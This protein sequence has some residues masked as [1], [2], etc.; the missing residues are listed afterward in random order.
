MPQ[1]HEIDYKIYGEDMQFVEVELDPDEA[2][3][4]EAGGMMYMEDGITMETIFGDGSGQQKSG[5]MGTL[6]G[7]GKRLLT[8]E[9]LFMTVFVN[10]GQGKKRLAFGAPYPGRILPIRL[11][12]VGGELIAQKDSFLCAAK[13]VAI[14]I[15]FQKRI[16]VG[17]FGGEG[18][19]MQRLTGDGLCFI[20]A[21]GML[22]ERVL[23]AG[24]TLR[25]DTGCIVAFQPSIDYDIQ[26]VSGIKTALFGGEGLFFATLKGPG[27]IWLQSLPLSRLAGR[28]VQAAPGS[29]RRREEGSIL[30]GL[31]N[32]LDG[33]G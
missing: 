27:K 26:M 16:G 30:G 22:H 1:A 25:V 31:G 28:I 9:S 4:A 8:G 24:E 29:G 32:L 10:K 15:A 33:D 2:A 18:F 21:G 7:A 12:D 19:I 20:H 23:A 14:G 5:L 3:V 17:L 6:M 11:P 13:G